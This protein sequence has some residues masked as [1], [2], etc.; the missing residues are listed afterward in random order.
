MLCFVAVLDW[1]VWLL[2]VRGEMLNYHDTN[3]GNTAD[4]SFRADQVCAQ[5]P[6]HYCYFNK[7]YMYDQVVV[8]DSLGVVPCTK[9]S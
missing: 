5:T 8:H 7:L 2:Q 9:R 4:R 3:R 1:C 6:Y